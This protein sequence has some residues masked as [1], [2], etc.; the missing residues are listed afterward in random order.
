MPQ[1]SEF[2]EHVAGHTFHF[3]PG[4]ACDMG[5]KAYTE[6]DLTGSLAVVIG[7]EG[8]GISRLVRE[9]CDFVVSIPMKGKITSLNASN[10]AAILMYEVVRQRERQAL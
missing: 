7:S 1:A 9:K 2:L 10:A 4:A 6:Q 3:M 5:G 8:T